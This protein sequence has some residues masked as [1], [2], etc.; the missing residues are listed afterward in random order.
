MWWG[1][2]DSLCPHDNDEGLPCL[3]SPVPYVGYREVSHHVSTWL[4]LAPGASWRELLHG[5]EVVERVPPTRIH[6][7]DVLP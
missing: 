2:L 7:E 4:D 5:P 3:G 1:T 6:L